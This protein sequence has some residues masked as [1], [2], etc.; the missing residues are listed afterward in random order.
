MKPYLLSV[1]YPAD[2]TR[3]SPDVLKRVMRDAGVITKDMKAAGAW[4]AQA[5]RNQLTRRPLRAAI[6]RLSAASCGV[7]A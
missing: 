7:G 3:P 4:V 5:K 1:C 2:S 6:T